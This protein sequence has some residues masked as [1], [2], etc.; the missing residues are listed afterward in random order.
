MTMMTMRTVSASVCSTSLIAFS[1]YPVESNA[2]FAC[3]PVGSSARRRSIWPRTRPITSS[4]LAFGSTQIPMNT[5]FLPGESHVGVVV[6]CAEL[7]VG[8]VLEPH[9]RAA[10]LADDELLEL[11]YGSQIRGRGDVQLNERALGLAH[12]G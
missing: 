12:R 5:A 1:M 2:M 11:V 3:M 9:V 8:D 4:E 6:V 7:H 10:L